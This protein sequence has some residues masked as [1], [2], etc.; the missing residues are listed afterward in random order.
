[1]ADYNFR[2]ADQ[3]DDFAEFFWTDENGYAGCD[4]RPMTDE[5]KKSVSGLYERCNTFTE[6][7]V[8]N[9]L[10]EYTRLYGQTSLLDVSISTLRSYLA[11]TM[12]YYLSDII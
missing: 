3:L 12:S 1:M 6:K 8:K 9:A 10:A 5:E 2:L 7:T 4:E 11:G